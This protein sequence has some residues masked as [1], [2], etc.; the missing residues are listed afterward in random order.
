MV[1]RPGPARWVL[2]LAR[3]IA[4]GVDS[5]G[6]TSHVPPAPKPT[7]NSHGMSVGSW[8]VLVN[9]DEAADS[10][11]VTTMRP[12]GRWT[13]GRRTSATFGPED[14]EDVVAAVQVAV[15]TLGA[16]RLF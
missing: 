3:L 11:T 9:Y 6:T 10:V 2:D 16:R 8:S 15:R 7:F 14:L 1:G 5:R 4:R 13:K 12:G